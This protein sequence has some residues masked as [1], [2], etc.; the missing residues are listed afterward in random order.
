MKTDD[1]DSLDQDEKQRGTTL[2]ARCSREF[3]KAFK[4]RWEEM[5]YRNREQALRALVAKFIDAGERKPIDLGLSKQGKEVLA[6]FAERFRKHPEH[7]KLFRN[8]LD[9]LAP[10]ERIPRVEKKITRP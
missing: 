9:A 5:G 1:V 7:V 2:F 3:N 10:S 4:Q 6:E 8:M